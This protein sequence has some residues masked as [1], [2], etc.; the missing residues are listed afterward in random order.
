MLSQKLVP[1]NG[2]G[3]F[4][5]NSS[6][7]KYNIPRLATDVSV[8][9]C[10][11]VKTNLAAWHRARGELLILFWCILRTCLI[12]IKS[13]YHVIASGLW[14]ISS[15]NKKKNFIS[16]NSINR[17]EIIG[18]CCLFIRLFRLHFCLRKNAITFM[19][20]GKSSIQ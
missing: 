18:G 2:R 12:A 8:Y 7:S 4:S 20:V 10:L 16:A 6:H 13:F 17:I 14:K 19:G 11:F 1:P 15:F 3:Y 9:G 5:S